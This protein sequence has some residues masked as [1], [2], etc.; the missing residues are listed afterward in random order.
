M[1]V[2][3]FNK[4]KLPLVIIGDGPEKSKLENIAESNIKFLG[5]ISDLDVE[6]YMSRCRAFVYAGVEDFGIAPIEAI[7]SGSPV[8]A[9]GKGGILD[10]VNCLSNKNKT[11]IS[12][13]LLFKKQTP[14]D[15]F[16]TISWFEDK[17]I[18]T[19]FDP[20]TMHNYAKSFSPKN[21]NIK[22][23]KSI[24]NAWEKFKKP[25]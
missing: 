18:W 19:K 4:L 23:E 8:I 1:L 9:F 16:D 5:K 14:E 24:N 11:K 3:A 22:F 10:T 13:G 7:A 25:F 21:F 12:T 17:K 20:E 6:I 15:V 2:K